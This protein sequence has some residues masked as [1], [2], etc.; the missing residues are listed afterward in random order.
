MSSYTDFSLKNYRFYYGI[1]HCHTSFS[2]GRG[3]PIEALDYGRKNNLDFMILTE[4]NS[5]LKDTVT[6][7]NKKISK[8]N[9]LKYL[10]E[11][12]NKKHEDFVAMLGF[13]TRSNPWGDFNIINSDKFFT[14]IVKDIRIFLLWILLNKDALVFINHPQ[15]Q[16]LDLSSENAILNYYFSGIELGNGSLP[17]KYTRFENYYI[18]MLDNGFHV[19]AIN[20]QDNHQVNFGDSENLTGIVCRHLDKNN[21]INALR[22]K[23]TFSTE[24]KTLKL[25]FFCNSSIMGSEIDSSNCLKLDF[26]IMCEDQKYNIIKIE[27]ITSKGKVIAEIDNL[28][29]SYIKYLYT[30]PINSNE[31]YY[32]A[33]IYQEE[34]KV[35]YSSPIFLSEF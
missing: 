2:T 11:R 30:H 32:F 8:W 20:S 10:I 22:K 23:T 21:L 26:L 3:T 35:A 34:N 15:A 29:L 33:K 6:L 17:N 25:L 19:C 24:S 12:Y 31:T 5:Y 18:K 13:E 1:P 4:D 16:I 28:N 9:Y 7:K 14:G 27:I